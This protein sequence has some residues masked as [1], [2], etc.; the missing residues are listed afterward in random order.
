MKWA[1]AFGVALGGN[2]GAR[3]V[4]ATESALAV[5]LLFA[6][7]R[8][9]FGR[10]VGVV[11]GALAVFLPLWV[12]FGRIAGHES[13]QI[14]GWTASMLALVCWLRSSLGPRGFLDARDAESTAAD[15]RSFSRGDPLA[16][17]ACV[18]AATITLWSKANGIWL[19]PVLGLVLVLR[20]R[21]ALARGVLPIPL[22]AVGGGVVA[23]LLT[24]A[25]WPYLRLRP[26]DQAIQL[27][28]LIGPGK[29]KG[30]I[31]FY[32][33][34]LSIPGWHYFA[35]A[36]LAQ[37]PALLLAAALAGLALAYAS[38]A[39]RPGGLVGVASLAWLVFPFF[40][41]V[42]TVRVGLARYVIQAWPPLL[43]FAALA[44]VALG[45]VVADL[46]LT[47]AFARR[48]WARFALRAAPAALAVAYTG[49]ALAK[50][51]PYPLD[52]F[53]EHVGGTAG[54]AARRT[55]EVP[56]W[57]EGNLAAVNALNETAPLG[58]RVFLALW[59]KH[60]IARLRDD[61]VV[62]SERTGA[63]YVLVSHLQYFEQAPP[64]CVVASTVRAGGAP[65]VDTYRCQVASPSQ[66]GFAA[67]GRNATDEAAAHFREARR[68]DP[69]DPAGIFGLG[70]VAQV[71]GDLP[72]AEALYL[73]AAP[74]A[75]ALGDTETEYY[76][77][78]DLGTAYAQEAKNEQAIDA[79]RAT[80]ALIERKPD[81][82]ADKT[83][84]VL[85]NLGRA[86]ALGGYEPEARAALDRASSLRPNDP[87]TRDALE[88][89]RSSAPP[90]APLRR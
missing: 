19:F 74:R 62:V 86:L 18:F 90:A 43:L 34:K 71:K 39:R 2:E 80:L 41:S 81:R 60:V 12:A 38:S 64:G 1:P 78:F 14:L 33:G 52:Y 35:Y 13:Q 67:M 50:I 57:G 53:G 65:L 85:L 42:S 61:L 55:F 66:L 29:P 68:R 87:A 89:L 44:L 58:A 28:Y 46:A 21:R 45:D 88:L 4:S 6:F 51:E 56:C 11:A 73:E 75:A 32:L 37:T 24:F 48:G 17:F 82:L 26:Y 10:A 16:A 22:A 54:V 84:N 69:G 72:L 3:V 47:F 20:S 77:R 23:T 70:W 27:A 30:P 31:E 8:V 79:F 36:F 40:Q 59:P 49:S 7:G 83:W 25:S 76:A 15:A 9:A 63:D 5:A